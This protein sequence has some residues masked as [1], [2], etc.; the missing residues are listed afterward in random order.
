MHFYL[1]RALSTRFLV[2]KQVTQTV[3]HADRLETWNVRP[4]ACCSCWMDLLNTVYLFL[5][6]WNIQCNLLIHFFPCFL[7]V[8]MLDHLFWAPFY[9]YEL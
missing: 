8:A 1:Y 4:W 5:F 9:A 2:A 3:R 7:P 6:Y